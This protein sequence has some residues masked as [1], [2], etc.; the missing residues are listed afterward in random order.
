MKTTPSMT[1][2]SPIALISHGIR[3]VDA[4]RINRMPNINGMAKR[5]FRSILLNRLFKN[6]LVSLV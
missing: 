2:M 4:K 3:V 5:I 6:F 1:A